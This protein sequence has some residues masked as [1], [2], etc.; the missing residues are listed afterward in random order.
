MAEIATTGTAINED[1]SSEII[2]RVTSRGSAKPVAGLY[3]NASLKLDSYETHTLPEEAVGSFEGKSYAFESVGEN[4]FRLL[5]VDMGANDGGAIEIINA[6][7]LMG[8]KLVGK[9]AYNLLMALKNK[10]DE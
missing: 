5:R 7:G 1:G 9:G 2:A 6:K 10:A 8:K 4:N 3:V